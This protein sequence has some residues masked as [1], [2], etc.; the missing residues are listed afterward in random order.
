[1]I[2]ARGVPLQCSTQWDGLGHIFDHGIGERKD[3]PQMFDD[4]RLGFPATPC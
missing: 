4:T 2:A 3:V 1:M